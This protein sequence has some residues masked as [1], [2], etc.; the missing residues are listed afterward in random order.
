LKKIDVHENGKRCRMTVLKAI[1]LRQIS[2]ALKG[3]QKA[4]LF[5]LSMDPEFAP[6]AA[7]E[8]IPQ[9]AT[10]NELSDIY[11]SLVRRVG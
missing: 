3:D 4:I 11:R 8:E 10:A 6:P 1:I 9:N 5:I 2:L 7:A